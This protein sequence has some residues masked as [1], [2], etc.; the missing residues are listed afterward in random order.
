[1]VLYHERMTTEIQRRI[2]KKQEAIGTLQQK[3]EACG[4]QIEKTELTINELDARK[5][6]LQASVTVSKDSIDKYTRER[7]LREAQI[8]ELESLDYEYRVVSEEYEEKLAKNLKEMDKADL[9]VMNFLV[10]DRKRI[11]KKRDKKLSEIVKRSGTVYYN[12]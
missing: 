7:E 3:I 10:N 6:R 9:K 5:A 12:K 8:K 11:E 1:M 4:R 2:S